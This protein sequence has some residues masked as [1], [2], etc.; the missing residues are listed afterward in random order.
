MCHLLSNIERE[1][2]DVQ[3]ADHEVEA[4]FIGECMRVSRTK[5]NN[6][7]SHEVEARKAQAFMYDDDGSMTIAVINRNQHK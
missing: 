4:S 3:K 5:E 6:F 2:R 7:E 1:H